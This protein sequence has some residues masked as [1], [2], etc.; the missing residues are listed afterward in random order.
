MKNIDSVI[1][2]SPP[3]EKS[4]SAKAKKRNIFN[5]INELHK[6][7]MKAN[8]VEEVEQLQAIG[9][10]SVRKNSHILI[11]FPAQNPNYKGHYH[12]LIVY[13]RVAGW[14]GEEGKKRYLVQVTMGY[15]IEGQYGQKYG[16]DN[17]PL[18]EIN[19]DLKEGQKPDT[20]Y[21]IDSKWAR[22]RRIFSINLNK[23][24]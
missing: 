21:T 16:I 8:K 20:S 11:H 19:M 6:A 4:P 9:P 24:K 12:L 5:V 3:E 15:L 10:I 1:T 14:E 18:T 22:S 7:G 13:E 2:D 17:M 23:K